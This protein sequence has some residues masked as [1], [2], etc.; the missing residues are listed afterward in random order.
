ML[1]ALLPLSNGAR[2]LGAQNEFMQ[3]SQ[4]F[5]AVVVAQA[6]A[7]KAKPQR[8][9]AETVPVVEFVD[10]SG[11][12]RTAHTNVASYP[13][14]FELGDRITVRVHN[15]N[16]SDVRVASFTGLWFESTFYLLPG[17]LTFMLGLWLFLKNRNGS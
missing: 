8:A 6:P 13:P 3:V 10:I 2:I 15:S 11:I 7:N 16:E 9:N 1:L 12:R 17:A 5:D 4:P 14:A